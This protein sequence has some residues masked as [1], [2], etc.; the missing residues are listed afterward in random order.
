MM[1]CAKSMTPLTKKNDKDKALSL[2]K[3]QSS[4]FNEYL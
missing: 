1:I 2:P 4:N 3:K